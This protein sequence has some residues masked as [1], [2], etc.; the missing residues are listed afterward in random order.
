MDQAGLLELAEVAARRAGDLLLDRFG[1]PARGLSSKTSPTDLVSDADRDAERLLLE[2]IRDARPDDGI[3]AEESGTSTSATGLTW[4]LD[5]LDGTVNYLFGIPLWCVSV[6][7]EDAD[8]AVAAVVHDP[9]R[10]E[11]FTATKGGGARL[12]RTPLGISSRSELSTALIATGF[13]YSADVRARQAELFSKVIRRVRDIRRGG[14]AALDLAW[15]AAG[16]FDGFYEAPMGPWDKA[17][18]VLLVTEA[19]GSVT[20]LPAPRDKNPGV[21]AGGRELH[22]QLVS[23]VLH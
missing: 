13:A 11:T 6:A 3:V 5:P 12:N 1:G 21:I 4:V 18:G 15:L 14:S 20:P 16:R 2:V 9:N 17:A 23:L 7:V 19:G 22:D 10:N 8:D